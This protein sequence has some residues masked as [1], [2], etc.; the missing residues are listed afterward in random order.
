MKKYLKIFVGMVLFGGVIMTGCVNKQSA[1]KTSE[2]ELVY[3]YTPCMDIGRI[4][5][6]LEKNLVLVTII[7]DGNGCQK[8]DS[9]AIKY[10]VAKDDEANDKARENLSDKEM[11]Y[12]ASHDLEVYLEKPVEVQ[13]G[14]VVSVSYDKHERE[15]RD[16]GEI[17]DCNYV[18]TS[19]LHVITEEEDE[20]TDTDDLD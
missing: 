4:T 15:K 12:I 6:I 5:K 14:D 16:I 20:L 18:R 10:D 3:D 7:Q 17:K 2:E 8:G 9:L 1:K 19:Y 13:V 11:E